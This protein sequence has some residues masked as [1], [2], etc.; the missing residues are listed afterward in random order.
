M[1]KLGDLDQIARRCPLD[2]HTY[3][4]GRLAL[5]ACASVPSSR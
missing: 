3:P 4:T 2:P 5:K 1:P